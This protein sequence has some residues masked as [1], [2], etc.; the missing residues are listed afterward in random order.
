MLSPVVY[1]R[2]CDL[3]A[4]VR[5]AAFQGVQRLRNAL[6]EL[7]SSLGRGQ[8]AAACRRRA[9]KAENLRSRAPTSWKTVTEDEVG[10]CFRASERVKFTHVA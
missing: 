5:T 1:R 9:A 2:R 10:W 8:P 7:L 3:K 4:A 6:W